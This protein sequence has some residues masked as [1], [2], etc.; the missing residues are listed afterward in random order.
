MMGYEMNL[1]NMMNANDVTDDETDDEKK[2]IS[3]DSKELPD[4]FPFTGDQVRMLPKC[5]KLYLITS[6]KHAYAICI[7]RCFHLVTNTLKVN[8]IFLEV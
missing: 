7:N 3:T 8:T 1:V 2:K 6:S 4:V 5:I